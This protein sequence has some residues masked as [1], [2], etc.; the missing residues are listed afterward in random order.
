MVGVSLSILISDIY[1]G[2]PVFSTR[3]VSSL[4]AP[5]H[6]PNLSTPHTVLVVEL[7]SNNK[8]TNNEKW[9]V[10]AA[11]C[12]YGFRDALSPMDRY[13]QEKKCEVKTSNPYDATETK[14]I[15]Y[16]LTLPFMTATA[17]DRKML[18]KDRDG[19]L[20]FAAFVKTRIREAEG[21]FNR[22]MLTGTMPDFQ[23]KL[24][25]FISDLKEHMT[26]FVG[27]C[28][29]MEKGVKVSIT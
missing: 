17:Q 18:M 6:P 1:V 11:G 15:D 26:E 5:S 12:Q 19:R 24:D 21:G 14:D 4:T 20:H 9:I 10:D 27:Q 7:R 25:D 28:S 13:Y 29:G 22:G 23:V 3:L 8:K 16:F 2:K